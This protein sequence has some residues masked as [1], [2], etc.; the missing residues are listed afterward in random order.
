MITLKEMINREVLILANT[1]IPSLIEKDFEAAEILN[2]ACY[3]Q[4]ADEY[5]EVFQYWVVSDWLCKKLMEK[6]QPAAFVM[7]DLPIWGRTTCGQGLEDDECLKT[8][9][10]DMVNFLSD[11]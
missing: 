8:I 2:D 10:N 9:Y 5:Q 7:D 1:A 11:Y 3:D 6:N 4:D